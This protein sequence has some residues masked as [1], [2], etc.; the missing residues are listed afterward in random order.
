[1]QDLNNKELRRSLLG[2]IHV[3]NFRQ[4]RPNYL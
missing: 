3:T 1:M 2:R 4:G